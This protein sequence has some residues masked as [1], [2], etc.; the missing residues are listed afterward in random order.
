MRAGGADRADGPALTP[1]A[2]AHLLRLGPRRPGRDMLSGEALRLCAGIRPPGP[3]WSL[4]EGDS[5]LGCAGVVPDGGGGVMWS[6]LSDA[7]RDRRFLLHRLA[8][9]LVA[10]AAAEFSPLRCF[11]RA[12]FGDAARWAAA[13][14]FRPLRRHDDFMRTGEIYWEYTMSD[15]VTYIAI[16]S[17]IVG[18]AQTASSARASAK[19]ASYQAAVAQQQAQTEAQIL[20]AKTAALRRDQSK[21]LAGRRAALATRGFDLTSG[22]A[23]LSQEQ[24]AADQEFDA[25]LFRATGGAQ[26]FDAQAQAGYAGLS[27]SKARRN[28]AFTAG[29]SLLTA[30]ET[31]IRTARKDPYFGEKDEKDKSK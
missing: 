8:R 17:A 9:R 23:L 3:A 10:E 28:A 16:A 25:L 20:A 24:I 30:A 19:Q 7:L 15:P 26:L 31:T 22:S 18:A 14:G 11:V 21:A 29:T 1:F 12:S 13:L 4:I 2:P 6:V 5:V 27:A